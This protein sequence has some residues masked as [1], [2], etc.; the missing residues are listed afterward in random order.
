MF[1]TS[2]V[3]KYL[4]KKF[5]E[6]NQTRPSTTSTVPPEKIIRWWPVCVHQVYLGVEFD[7]WHKPKNGHN[8]VV[9]ES[10]CREDILPLLLVALSPLINMMWKSKNTCASFSLMSRGPCP[11]TMSIITIFPPSSRGATA[12]L[13]FFSTLTHSSS[14]QSCRVDWNKE[15]SC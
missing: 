7:D 14:P 11:S 1:S 12:C 4:F 10:C 13:H 5:T 15:A 2:N 9:R 8:F 3:E 6:R